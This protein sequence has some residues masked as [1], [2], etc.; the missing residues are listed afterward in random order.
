M[1]EFAK[2]TDLDEFFFG[3]RHV[4]DESW[5]P[6]AYYT[7][8]FWGLLEEYANSGKSGWCHTQQTS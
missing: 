2:R 6:D 5:A 7:S 8:T 4:V 3:G 1:R